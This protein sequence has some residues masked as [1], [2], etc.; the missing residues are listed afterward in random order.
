MPTMSHDEDSMS[1]ES[2]STKLVFARS[3]PGGLISLA[4]RRSGHEFLRR[5]ARSSAL[6][7][8]TLSTS[9][10]GITSLEGE[11]HGQ[12]KGQ[13][14]TWAVFGGV[15]EGKGRVAPTT[16]LTI[17]NKDA[18]KLDVHEENVGRNAKRVI[19]VWTD[20]PKPLEGVKVVVSSGLDSPSSPLEFRLEEVNPG[21]KAGVWY[22]DFPIVEGID[23]IGPEGKGDELTIPFSQGLVI[24]NPLAEVSGNGGASRKLEWSYPGFLTMQWF[25]YYNRGAVGLYW[26]THD[27]LGFR[28]DFLFGMN[29]GRT[30]T[31]RVR[32]YPENMGLIGR[33]YRA[34]YPFVVAT[35]K[36][37]WP[38]ASQ[39]YRTW[40]TSQPWCRRGK[41]S[42]R[43]DI[44]DWMKDVSLWVWNRGAAARVMPGAFEL[45]KR[46]G[47]NVALDW[48]WWHNNPYDILMPEYLPPRE[49][50]ATFV[51]AVHELQSEGIKVIVYINGR[52]WDTESRSWREEN[53][54]LAAVKDESLKPYG[55]RYNVFVPGHVIA[56]MCPTTELWMSKMTSVVNSLVRDLS[57]DG[58]YLDQI[59]IYPA[60]LCFDP[61]HDHPVGGGNY[62]IQGYA[63]LMRRAREV[64]R[65]ANPQ[66]SL[67]S[68]SCVELYIDSFD[69][70]LT[71]D[72]TWERTGF[73]DK[74]GPDCEPLPL[75]NVV[76]HDY[77]LTFGSYTSMTNV[78]P[79]DDLW[80][81]SSRPPEYGKFVSYHDKYPDQF[82]FELARNIVW[83]IQPMVTNVYPEMLG[84]DEFEPDMGFLESLARFHAKAKEYLVLGRWL[85]PPQV[86]CPDVEVKMSVGSIY[87]SFKD[88]RERSRTTPAVLSSAWASGDGRCCTVFVNF[89]NHTIDTLVRADMD[90]YGFESR[91]KIVMTDYPD[92]KSR[93]VL[94]AHQLETK[95]SLSPR[96]IV[97][98]EFS[99]EAD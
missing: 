8:I 26:A 23:W 61:N 34:P 78:P 49:G 58:V 82:A 22:V 94:E 62:W 5:P 80:P 97:A 11:T 42:Q 50:S 59:S 77:A 68:E 75:F 27:S 98:Y 51:K 46:T 84:K 89:T 45:R 85:P 36:G 69:A 17:T 63:E 96:S 43:T 56:P 44:P 87:T 53:A 47:V 30:I 33:P 37:G 12:D 90:S 99:P 9:D 64:S 15:F 88:R 70:F 39:I 91:D 7:E 76:Y 19:M 52:L 65:K 60:N 14:A 4:D 54:D 95:L 20:F 6:W 32:N 73:I 57:L 83:G 92:R 29:E 93:T 72:S 28:K 18:R 3:P 2:D 48:Y 35:F 55:E 1:L 25:S 38:E 81:E 79:Y 74:Y 66:A 86:E 67:T 41:L 16:K 13:S 24:R 21:P 10:L 31:L 40:A 71:F